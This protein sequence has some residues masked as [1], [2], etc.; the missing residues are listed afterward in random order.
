MNNDSPVTRRTKAPEGFEL[1]G[2]ATIRM[3]KT[4]KTKR[5]VRRE[6]HSKKKQVNTHAVLLGTEKKEKNKTKGCSLL[7]EEEKKTAGKRSRRAGTRNG[8][9]GEGAR[10]V[11]E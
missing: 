1:N 2:T 3:V 6:K 8:I 9:T 7:A 10:V 4:G 11:M 5:V